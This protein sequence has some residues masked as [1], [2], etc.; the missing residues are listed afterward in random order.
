MIKPHQTVLYITTPQVDIV[1][2]V[3]SNLYVPL[4]GLSL[5]LNGKRTSIKYLS[6]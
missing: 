6:N 3:M 5:C 2:L 4:S 1:I